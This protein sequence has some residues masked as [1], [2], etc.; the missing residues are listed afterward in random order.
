MR[1]KKEYPC[2]LGIFSVSDVDCGC[3][4]D[5]F[6]VRYKIVGARITGFILIC[7]ACGKTLVFK[8]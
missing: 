2:I 6:E 1:T 3:G 4:N 8:R 7:T 5:G